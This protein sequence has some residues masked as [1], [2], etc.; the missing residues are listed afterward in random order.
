MNKNLPD[1]IKFQI[2][3]AFDSII[4]EI[5]SM[6]RE[7][8]EGGYC[9]PNSV[10][11]EAIEIKELIKTAR[12]WDDKGIR[13][14]TDA[15]ILEEL[16]YYLAYIDEKHVTLCPDQMAEDA[17]NSWTDDQGYYQY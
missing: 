7:E 17:Y 13:F 2:E 9:L 3:A 16:D 5:D 10:Y 15:E 11:W 8:C 1:S 12:E 6:T 14:Y 4:R